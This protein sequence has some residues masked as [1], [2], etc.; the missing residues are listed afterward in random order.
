MT[1]ADKMTL[2]KVQNMSEPQVQVYDCTGDSH[3]SSHSSSVGVPILASVKTTDR[4]E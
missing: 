1:I 4:M 3:R 2:S